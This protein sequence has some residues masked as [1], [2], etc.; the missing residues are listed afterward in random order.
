[1]NQALED[2]G[3]ESS[4]YAHTTAGHTTE[5][6]AAR[7]FG[8]AGEDVGEADKDGKKSGGA[9]MFDVLYTKSYIDTKVTEFF[10]GAVSAADKAAAHEVLRELAWK[11]YKDAVSSE[12]KRKGGDKKYKSV[13][14][15]GRLMFYDTPA[16]ATAL[17]DNYDPWVQTQKKF[18]A[19]KK[20]HPVTATSSAAGVLTGAKGS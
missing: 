1:M 2:E 17:H 3:K 19:F 4:V 20:A 15:I 12:H 18:K 7:V 13:G 10:P 11:H 16:A 5:N 6:F 9:H 14:P 8:K